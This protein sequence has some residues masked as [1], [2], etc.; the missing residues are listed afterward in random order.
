MWIPKD[1][2]VIFTNY[3]SVPKDQA[4]EET[5]LTLLHPVIQGCFHPID[6]TI[7]DRITHDDVIKG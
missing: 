4:L 1:R 7:E 3:P 5:V 2:L 6:V